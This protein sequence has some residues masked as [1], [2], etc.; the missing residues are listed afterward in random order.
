M[1]IAGVFLLEPYKEV[2][3]TGEERHLSQ[4]WSEGRADC[5]LPHRRKRTHTADTRDRS[6]QHVAAKCCIP[7][8]S[9]YHDGF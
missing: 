5:V 9:G 3:N 6:F 4:G 1:E 7:T 2:V 8:K